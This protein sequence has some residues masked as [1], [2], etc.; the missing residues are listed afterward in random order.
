MSEICVAS[1]GYWELDCPKS[2]KQLKSGFGDYSVSGGQTQAFWNLYNENLKLS[3]LNPGDLLGAGRGQKVLNTLIDMFESKH[4]KH[5]PDVQ[6]VLNTA[7]Y[8]DPNRMSLPTKA[9]TVFPEDVLPEP[10]ATAF[11]NRH[12]LVDE[13]LE[14]S[15]D[16][17]EPCFL[18]HRAVEA[19]IR[20]KLLASGMA[21]LCPVDEVPRRPDGRPLL[22]GLFSVAHKEHS[23]RLIFDR[24]PQNFSEARLDWSFLPL[25]QQLT[26]IWIPPGH[27]IRGSGDDL[28]SYFYQL[29]NAETS[30][31]RSAFG[32]S[33]DGSLH[34]ECG[35]IPGTQYVLCLNVVAMGDRSATDIGQAVHEA[36]LGA[37]GCMTD[38]VK[39]VWG[40][41]IPRGPVYE[42]T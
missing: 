17:P 38:E 40:R 6:S 16:M 1:F 19:S 25:G 7:S 23:D 29:R 3:R 26:R 22:G 5:K 12:R 20:E 4:C 33:F 27:G 42:G 13:D 32:R 28:K 14:K 39:L 34:P 15:F 10:R 24:R 41:A 11:L 37:F 18:V 9:A 36:A 31:K 21:R 2:Y 35:G 8:V 30:V